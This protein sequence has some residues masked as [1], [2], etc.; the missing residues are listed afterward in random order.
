MSVVSVAP[1]TSLT[2]PLSWAEV[3]QIHERIKGLVLTTIF[4]PHPSQ[5]ITACFPALQCVQA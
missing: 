5:A 2:A 4:P 1:T 3:S